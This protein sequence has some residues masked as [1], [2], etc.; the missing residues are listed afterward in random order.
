MVWALRGPA[1][2]RGARAGGRRRRRC[3]P[4]IGARLD[5]QDEGGARLASTA[6]RAR[7]MPGAP[8]SPTS[9]QPE[10]TPRRSAAPAFARRSRISMTRLL[11]VDP[12]DGPAALEG[13]DQRHLVGVLEIAADR[14]AAG[15]P[16]HRRRRCRRGARRGTSPS[17]RPR[18]SGSWPGSTSSNG[19]PVASGL[20]DAGEQLADLEALGPDPVDR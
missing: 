5:E 9:D 10:T 8:T 20:V 7:P 17:P 13:S 1:V 12:V 16:G 4:Q 15:D 3:R 14:D 6:A 19:S 18:A 11:I 2:K